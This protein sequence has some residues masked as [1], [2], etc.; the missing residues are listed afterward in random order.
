MGPALRGAP[1]APFSLSDDASSVDLSPSSCPEYSPMPDTLSS[2]ASAGCPSSLSVAIMPIAATFS[3]RFSVS[4][5]S[6]DALRSTIICKGGGCEGGCEGG[7]SGWWD[8]RGGARAW[9]GYAAC[10]EGTADV[11][12]LVCRLETLVLHAH[13]HACVHACMCTRMHMYPYA[14]VHACICTRMHM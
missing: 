4:S 11:A 10:E 13:P 2:A 3:L 12:E 8:A 1:P 7:R 6:F 14:Y 9:R 5:R